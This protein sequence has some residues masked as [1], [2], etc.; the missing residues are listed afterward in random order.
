LLDDSLVIS[1]ATFYYG[2]SG[3]DQVEFS[4]RVVDP[5][6]IGDSITSLDPTSFKE[7]GHFTGTVRSD[8]TAAITLQLDP[9]TML[10]LLKT[11]SL[12]LAIVPVNMT[13]IRALASVE[14]S[15]NPPYIKLTA[16]DA[17]GTH[18]STKSPEY[19]YHIVKD[20]YSASAGTF[21]LRGSAARRERITIDT[22]SMREDLGL[23]PFVTINK[24]SLEFTYDQSLLTRGTQPS[25]S[26]Y[27]QLIYR[28]DTA[29]VDTV[30]GFAAYAN[31]SG[32]TIKYSIQTYLEY[33]V[34][35]S[36]DSLTFELWTGLAG[37]SFGGT[38]AGA[39]D[40][41]LNRWVIFGSDATDQTKRPHLSIIYSYLK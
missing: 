35:H 28:V 40:Y 4:V 30:A 6:R 27:P 23:T 19:D 16:S 13:A 14:N 29:L 7:V 34:R 31:P 15:T 24:A 25:D 22:K 21:E 26:S 36:L 1:L 8:T 3:S 5:A 12:A 41:N 10:P 17:N 18:F 37:R 38:S 11:A 20:D 33:A 39:E 9:A 2:P 32:T